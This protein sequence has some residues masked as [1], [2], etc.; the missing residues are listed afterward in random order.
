MRLAFIAPASLKGLPSHPRSTSLPASSGRS[1]GVLAP[2][3]AAGALLGLAACSGQDGPV[4]PVANAQPRQ[5]VRIHGEADPALEVEVLARYYTAGS[6]CSV[7]P[8]LLQ[9][10]NGAAA[11]PRSIWVAV[12]VKR[13]GRQYEARVALDHF[14]PGECGWHPFTIGFKVTSGEGISTVQAVPGSGGQRLEPG[15]EPRIWVDSAVRRAASPQAANDPRGRREVRPLELTCA[16]NQIRGT[17]ALSCVPDSPR[18]LLLISEDA[19]EV[20]VDFR[21]LT[22]M[23]VQ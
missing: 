5:L 7:A 15:P 11:T 14:E 10:L 9:R 22:A 21:D 2:L 1:S 16:A 3:A 20:R 8:G 4:E 23:P 6:R 17:K 12:P 19:A 13:E 18:E